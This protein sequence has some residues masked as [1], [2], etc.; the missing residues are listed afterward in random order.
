[1]IKKAADRDL[2]VS[3]FHYE[4]EGDVIARV[5][6]AIPLPEKHK[7]KLQQICAEW[8]RFGSFRKWVH[9]QDY[10]LTL[11]F[12]GECDSPQVKQIIS[13]LSKVAA[14][15][16]PFSLQMQGMGTFGRKDQPRILWAGVTGELFALHQLQQQIGTY[17]AP[18]GF[19]IEE[20]PYRPHI[21]IARTYL[22]NDFEKSMLPMLSLGELAEDTWRVT[23]I[24]LYETRS[25]QSPMYHVI[26]RFA[27]NDKF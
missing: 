3:S 16:A 19:P 25:R 9:F 13:Q 8:K 22:G 17:L 12:L 18:L 14:D 4:K 7:A 11:Q 10:H 6:V 2:D 24:V 27:F 15:T 23:E 1:M 20:R 21:T 26:E 5:F